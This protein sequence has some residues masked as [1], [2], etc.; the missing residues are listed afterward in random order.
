M[1]YISRTHINDLRKKYEYIIG[2]G[3]G[4]IEFEQHYNPSMYKLDYMVNGQGKNV[5]EKVCG[6]RIYGPELVRELQ[7]KK[8]CVVIYPNI[9]QTC[10]N[11]IRELLPNADTIIGRLVDSDTSYNYASDREDLIIVNLIEQMGIKNPVYMDIGVCHPVVRNN[12]FMLY[13]KGYRKGYLIEPNPVMVELIKQYRSDNTILHM[14]VCAG[15]ETSLTYVSGKIPGLNHFLRDGEC[16]DESENEVLRIPVKNINE[17]FQEYGITELDV[18]DTDT[19][20]MDYDIVKEL[21]TDRFKVKI[22]CI[23]KSG[24][25]TQNIRLLMKNKGYIHFVST[26][27]N[28]IYVHK[29][30]WIW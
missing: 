12:T 24:V 5:D 9:E 6:C 19:E 15:K 13:E 23:E 27:Q 22:I 1:K 28:D 16:V 21:D 8:I 14:G 20:G 29:D 30:A 3:N 26:R 7:E 11:Q 17:V 18:L 2:W 4:A 25:P 10:L